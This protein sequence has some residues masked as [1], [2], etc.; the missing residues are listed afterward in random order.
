MAGQIGHGFFWLVV[1]GK[2]DHD[3]EKLNALLVIFGVGSNG[4]KNIV[5]VGWAVLSL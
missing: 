2:L 3:I 4:E 5:K 1:M